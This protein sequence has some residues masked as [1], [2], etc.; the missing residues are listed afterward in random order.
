MATELKD[1]NINGIDMKVMRET[2]ES[3]QTDPALGRCR[4][5]VTNHWVDGDHNCTRVCGFYAGKA[6]HGHKQ[7]YELHA[8]EPPMLAGGDTSPNPTEHLLNALASCVTTS[9]IAHAAVRGI[10]IDALESEVE[11]D[12]DLRGFLGIDSKVPKGFT[13][14]RMRFKVR[15]D[16]KNFKKLKGLAE[17]SPVYNTL[18]NGTKVN[19]ELEPY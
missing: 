15:T 12:V 3:I 4:F 7:E 1:Q 9:M 5:R 19:I 16:P 10:Q 2:I 17:F 6:E 14:I 18:M 13:N 8:D 11:G